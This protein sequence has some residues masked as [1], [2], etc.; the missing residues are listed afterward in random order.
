MSLKL[1]PSK[2]SD[3]YHVKCSARRYARDINEIREKSY[4]NSEYETQ[5]S[6]I[7]N[8]LIYI[9]E[10][11]TKSEESDRMILIHDKLYDDSVYVSVMNSSISYLD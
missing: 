3:I 7:L 4:S 10:L 8:R 9:E 2:F 5:I 6:V 11:M 1:V